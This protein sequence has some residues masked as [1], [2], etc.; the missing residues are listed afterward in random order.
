MTAA[1]DDALKAVTAE[2]EQLRTRLS[3]GVASDTKALE[4]LLTNFMQ[5]LQA[6]PIP[7]A[8]PYIDQLYT[9][10]QDL[11]ELQSDF[12]RQQNAAQD[13]MEHIQTRLK[14]ATAYAKSSASDK[15]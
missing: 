1:L 15:R 14:A 13:A 2:V 5:T 7:V 3:E 11:G 12:K 8:K 6:T 9:L 10:A 4:P